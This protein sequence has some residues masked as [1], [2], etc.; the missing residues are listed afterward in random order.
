MFWILQWILLKSFSKPNVWKKIL[1]INVILDIGILSCNVIISICYV[2]EYVLKFRHG[3][4]I[5]KV[6]AVWEN[7][8]AI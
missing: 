4:F 8:I 1:N 7:I 6:N 5:V 3:L 2:K